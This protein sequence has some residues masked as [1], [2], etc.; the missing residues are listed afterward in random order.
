LV[1]RNDRIELEMSNNDTP[2]KRL[3]TWKRKAERNNVS[4]RTLDRWADAGII[5]R[6]EYIN[7]RKYSRVDAEPRRDPERQTAA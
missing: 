3:E 1:D 2:T 6:P 5:P 4:T 7:G